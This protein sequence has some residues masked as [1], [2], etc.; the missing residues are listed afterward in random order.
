MLYTGL[1]IEGS[2]TECPTSRLK[3]DVAVATSNVHITVIGA[4]EVCNIEDAN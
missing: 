4:A 2:R 1:R 3:E